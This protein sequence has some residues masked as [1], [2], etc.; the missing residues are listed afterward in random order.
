MGG[1]SWGL[2]KSGSAEEWGWGDVQSLSYSGCAE[3]DMRDGD[4]PCL[5]WFP[6]S[7]CTG[8]CRSQR[9]SQRE[10]AGGIPDP[11]S[12]SSSAFL[13]TLLQPWERSSPKDEISLDSLTPESYQ[14][15]L[16]PDPF[17][18]ATGRAREMPR[19]CGCGRGMRW[20]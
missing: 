20:G 13:T 16:T 14:L 8:S 6:P 18:K 11:T 1:G 15:A 3:L 7:T 2:M 4:E 17:W 5:S 9:G 12:T 10:Q 19:L